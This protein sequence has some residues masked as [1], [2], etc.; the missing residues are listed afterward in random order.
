MT[1][2]EPSRSFAVVPTYPPPVRVRTNGLA[3][4]SLVS[5]VLFLTAFGAVLAVIFGHIALGQIKR[6]GGWQRGNGM[7]VAGLVLGYAGVAVI[8]IALLSAGTFE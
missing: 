4:A 5:G 7:A 3:I 2:S 8:V 1:G 6:S